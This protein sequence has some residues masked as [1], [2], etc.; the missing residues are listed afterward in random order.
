MLQKIQD[1]YTANKTIVLVA[2][3][4]VVAFLLWKKFKK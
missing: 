1:F 3:S 4:V 2:V